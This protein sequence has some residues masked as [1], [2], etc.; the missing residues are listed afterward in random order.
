MSDLATRLRGRDDLDRVMSFGG[1]ALAAATAVAYTR[2]EESW[3]AFPLLLLAALPCAALFALALAP[4]LGEPAAAVAAEGAANRWQAALLAAGHFLLL[5]SL[6]SLVMVLGV[7]EPGDAT[8]TWTLAVTAVSALYFAELLDSPGLRLLGL[9]FA[10]AS[11][12]ALL[13]WVD[14]DAGATAFRNV[15]LLEAVGFALLARMLRPQRLEHS[16][17][18]VAV[19][20]TALIA[21]ATLGAFSDFQ[22]DLF[23]GFSSAVEGPPGDK[24]GWE[25]VLVVASLGALAYSGWQRYRGTVYPGLVGLVIFIG[26][27]ADG[28]LWGWPLIL[29]AAAVACFGWALYGSGDT[30]RPGGAPPREPVPPPAPPAA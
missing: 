16:H 28:S 26:I 13:S 27:S 30:T 1:L 5:L 10:G 8:F 11:L 19:A 24:D 2:M 15:L 20:A 6:L 21:G 4:G 9:L 12:L 23:A 3:A 18:A 25:L 14:D 17:V 29:L 22:F 7:D